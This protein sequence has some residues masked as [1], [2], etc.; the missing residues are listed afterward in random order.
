M[1]LMHPWCKIRPLSFVI[2]PHPEATEH[3]VCISVQNFIH[4]LH[5]LCC[6]VA[7]GLHLSPPSLLVFIFLLPH[8]G[9]LKDITSPS[10]QM[11]KRN[12]AIHQPTHSTANSV[13]D[14]AKTL[15]IH[16]Y[17][18][19]STHMFQFQTLFPSFFNQHVTAWLLTMSLSSNP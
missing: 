19:K 1:L 5:L 13:N 3:E 8:G 7:H 9:M 16:S 18:L 4:F 15:L 11:L 2:L 6:T 14:P 10:S 17:R 12:H